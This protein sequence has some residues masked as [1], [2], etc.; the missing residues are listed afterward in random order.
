MATGGDQVDRGA[1]STDSRADDDD[2]VTFGSIMVGQLDA[3]VS[4]EVTNGPARLDAWIDFNGDGCW[5]GPMEQIFDS[6]EVGTGVT[7]TLKNVKPGRHKVTV[8]VSD[9]SG[10]SSTQDFE[11]EVKKK[12]VEDDSPGFG[13]VLVAL[14]LLGAV[15]VLTIRRR[16]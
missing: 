9:T 10:E 11:F 5:G 15:S 16:L 14:A 1:Q 4:V 12:G 7:L 3:E 13:T 6:V 2:G 8:E